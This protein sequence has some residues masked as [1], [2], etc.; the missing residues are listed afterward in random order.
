MKMLSNW[1]ADSMNDM[2]ENK[3]RRCCTGEKR[4]R[5]KVSFS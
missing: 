4:R 1:R 2:R 3:W 5:E